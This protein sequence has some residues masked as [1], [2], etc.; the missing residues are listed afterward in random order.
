MAEYE[1]VLSRD[2]FKPLTNKYGNEIRTL[3]DSFKHK[4]LWVRPVNQV[5]FIKNDPADD[6]FL[7]C[8]LEAKV[9]YIITGNTR[10]FPLGNFNGIK[11][12]TPQ[13]FISQLISHTP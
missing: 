11:I 6:K 2:K 3:F 5:E 8:A 10:H 13:E 4:A 9:D 1:G 12:V 7:D